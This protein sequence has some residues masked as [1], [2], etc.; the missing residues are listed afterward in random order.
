MSSSTSKVR[1]V[2]LDKLHPYIQDM[3]AIVSNTAA[4]D[5]LMTTPCDFDV[6][7]R[8]D[9]AIRIDFI[10]RKYQKLQWAT[11]KTP[12]DPFKAIEDL[13]FLGLFHAMNLGRA[14]EKCDTM[15]PIHAA[16]QSGDP[17]MIAIAVCCSLDLDVLD[18]NGWTPLVYAMYYGNNEAARFLLSMG[19]KREKTKIDLSTLTIY[20]GDRDMIDQLAAFGP[21]DRE[22]ATFKPVSVKFAKGKNALMTEL[23]VPIGTRK[24]CKLYRETAAVV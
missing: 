14:E 9:E 24:L 3:L 16:V 7:P 2:Q 4:N 8:T 20:N 19:A 12:P 1:S 21:R 23:L 10:T 22:A 13:D 5:L 18:G 17:V 6:G 15:M 11:Q